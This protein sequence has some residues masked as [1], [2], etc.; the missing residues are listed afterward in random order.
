MFIYDKIVGLFAG[1]DLAQPHKANRIMNRLV[2][3][4][5]AALLISAC[6]VPAAPTPFTTTAALQAPLRASASIPSS[7]YLSSDAGRA[8]TLTATRKPPTTETPLPATSVAATAA[9]SA[10]VS[11]TATAAASATARRPSCSDPAGRIETGEFDVRAL[12]TPLKYRVYL[13]PC[14]AQEAT[15]RYPTLYLFHGQGFTDDQ[16]DRMGIDETADRLILADQITPLIIVMPYERYGGQPDETAFSDS[17]MQ[18]VLPYIDTHYRT[19]AD[20]AHRAVGGLSRGA[21]WA[22]HFGFSQPESFCAVGAHSPA[23]FYYD[24]QRMRTWIAKLPAHQLPRVY[25]D[26]GARDRPEI[27]DSAEWLEKLLDQYQLIHEW[28]LFAGYHNEAYWSS[29]LEQYLRWYT[30]DW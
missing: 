15:R 22:V 29:H 19:Q 17:M 7:T 23:V 18:V 13:P 11:P 2:A 4:L 6:T 14:Y 25:I 8:T 3:L 20:R 16:W 21:G 27:M 10:T 26:I 1:L 24:A 12:R 9:A 5:I 28:H 30:Q